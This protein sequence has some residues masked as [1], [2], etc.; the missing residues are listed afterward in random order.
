VKPKS[1]WK[2]KRR[3]WIFFF[4]AGLCFCFAAE[5]GQAIFTNGTFVGGAGT[6]S[7]NPTGTTVTIVQTTPT[8]IINWAG[9]LGVPGT[10]LGIGQT[11]L[12]VQP[13]HLSAILNRDVSGLPSAIFGT[14][15][16]NGRV[17]VINPAG[18]LVAPTAVINAFGFG[19]STLNVSDTDFLG[20]FGSGT[21]SPGHAVLSTGGAPPTFLAVL[22]GAQINAGQHVV[23][24]GSELGLVAGGKVQAPYIGVVA[25]DVVDI[26]LGTTS[27][28]VP[29]VVFPPAGLGFSHLIAVTN[30]GPI[31]F[32]GPAGAAV[33]SA[34]TGSGAGGQMD[35]WG[36]AVTFV[37][38]SLVSAS[39]LSGDTNGGGINVRGSSIT[40]NPGAS[41]NAN[42]LGSGSGGAIVF[43]AA[44]T[45]LTNLGVINALPGGVVAWHG[46]AGSV[47]GVINAGS[48]IT[49]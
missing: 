13:T 47:G 35:V 34:F 26:A 23:L 24:A 25:A 16:A 49:F 44:G 37:G 19:V 38:G 29:P 43:N 36:A 12:F 22:P 31:A 21:S 27:P 45:T 6:I 15:T 48:V 3:S 11:A 40:L 28:I 5:K 14:L 1:F 46:G 7:Y 30:P 39:A 33:Y 32:P 2:E 8:A 4:W 20:F 10:T 41:V 42:G 17:Y 9:A 18:L